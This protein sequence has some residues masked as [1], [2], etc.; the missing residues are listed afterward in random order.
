MKLVSNAN[1]AETYEQPQSDGIEITSEMVSA[2]AATYLDLS[3]S[4]DS[5]YL[6]E[7]IYSAMERE[8]LS[9]KVPT[10]RR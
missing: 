4:V 8:R 3:E 6:V 9:Q 2:G 1:Q 7:A 5:Y 10:P